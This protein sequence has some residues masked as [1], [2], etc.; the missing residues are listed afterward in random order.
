MVTVDEE[1]KGYHLYQMRQNDGFHKF[2]G[3]LFPEE[4]HAD[5]SYSINL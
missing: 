5:R 2:L 1:N 4:I 3:S